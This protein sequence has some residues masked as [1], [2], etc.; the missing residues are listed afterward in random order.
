MADIVEDW[1]VEIDRGPDW[2]FLRLRPGKLGPDGVA[3]MLWSLAD[4]HF[5]YRLVLEMNDVEVLPSRLM[6]QLV[7]LQ[8]RVLQRDGALRLCGLSDD[9]AETL[10]FCR[11]DQ[12]LPNYDCR[13]DAVKGKRRQRATCIN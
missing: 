5:V 13:E 12:A 10:H 1:G 7:V 4:Q 8:N 9:C 2:L 6:G 3:D 11:L